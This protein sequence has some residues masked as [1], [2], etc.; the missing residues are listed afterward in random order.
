MPAQGYVLADAL[1][2]VASAGGVDDTGDLYI[3][4]G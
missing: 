1:F 3:V 2:G 4:D